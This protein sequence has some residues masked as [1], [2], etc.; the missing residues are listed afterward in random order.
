MKPVFDP[1]LQDDIPGWVIENIM[2]V[3]AWMKARNY[4]Q[5]SIGGIAPLPHCRRCTDGPQC[6]RLEQTSN[7][8]LRG[9]MEIKNAIIESVRL[10]SDDHGCLSAWLTLDYGDSAQGFGGY[11][12]YLPQGFKHHDLKS[13]AGHFIWR[14]MEVAGVTDWDKLK[15]KTVRVRGT[16]GG[17]EAIGHIIKDDWFDP[18]KDFEAASK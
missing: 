8:P 4:T 9:N 16:P 10:T 13:L 5:W 18:R 15:G 6:A 1:R 11:A 14:V 17:V 3:S 12:L 7:N 2:Q